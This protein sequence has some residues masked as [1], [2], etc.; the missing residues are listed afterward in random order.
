MEARAQTMLTLTPA[1]VG[2]ALPASTAKPTSLIALKA[3]ASMA[4]HAQ[5]KSTAIPVPAAQASL[6][7]T[8]NTRST[9]VTPSPASTEA[10]VK[11]LWSPSAAPALRATLATAARHQ[12][13]GADAHLPAKMED[14]VAKR[15][16][17]SSVTVLTAGLDV[18]VTSPGSL[19]RRLLA[20]EGS[21]QM[22]YATTAV[23][24]S[25]LGMP[26]IVNA[27]LTTL[28]A[29]AKAKW[30]TVRTNPATMAPPAGDMWEAT[31]VIVCRALLGRTAK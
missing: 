8:A 28:E 11:M 23:T 25:T 24:V 17:P 20:I 26:T 14:A 15:M 30:T 9:S 19:V 16:L 3:L 10:S 6:A 4:G 1:P 12:S 18:T 13:T 5:I 31:S 7:P 27:L 21:R 22:S 29:I 2:L